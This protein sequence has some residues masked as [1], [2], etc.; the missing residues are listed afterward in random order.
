[1]RYNKVIHDTVSFVKNEL[2]TDKEIEKLHINKAITEPCEINKNTT[3]FFFGARFSINAP[4]R[5]GR[6]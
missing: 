2:F 5:E 1:M 3:Y 6:H 4:Y